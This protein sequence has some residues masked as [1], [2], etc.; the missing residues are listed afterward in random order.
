MT[1]GANSFQICDAIDS[2]LSSN[3]DD[4]ANGQT[5]CQIIDILLTTV[6]EQFSDFQ[7]NNRINN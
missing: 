3:N 6:I 5:D 2:I 1:A 7:I 4:L